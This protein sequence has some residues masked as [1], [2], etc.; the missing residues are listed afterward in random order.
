MLPALAAAGQEGKIAHPEG[1]G[2]QSREAVV[3]FRRQT[4]CVVAKLFVESYLMTTQFKSLNMDAQYNVVR[5]AV[6]HIKETRINWKAATPKPMRITF[7]S[8]HSNAVCLFQTAVYRCNC[9]GLLVAELEPACDHWENMHFARRPYRQ[10]REEPN[11]D[12]ARPNERP[13]PVA[14]L[15]AQGKVQ[16]QQRHWSWHTAVAEVRRRLN[17]LELLQG[18]AGDG[19]R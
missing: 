17:I 16:A 13:R 9:C 5:V 11:V 4:D 6:K 2:S 3:A 14:R 19:I 18:Y 7:G 8:S 12:L 10:R 1:E 15:N